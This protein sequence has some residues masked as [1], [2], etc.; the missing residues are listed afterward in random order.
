MLKK[1][2]IA[3]VAAAAIST[4]A[5]AGTVGKTA[6]VGYSYL[7]FGS[8]ITGQGGTFGYNFTLPLDGEKM[9]VKGI[10]VGFGMN[11]DGYSLSSDSSTTIDS[12]AFGINGELTAG[13]RFLND[14]M[15]VQAGLGYGYLAV[16]SLYFTGMQYSGAV[17]YDITDKYGVEAIYTGTNYS[18]S[19]GSGNFDGS[20]VG[21]NLT[22]N[23]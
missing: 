18:P 23:F 14:K 22:I 13:Y 15:K 9:P 17:S 20:K 19:I 7:D 2:I 3:A 12:T 11:F 8:G 4:S 10:E 5:M 6:S 1:I 16:N 21:V